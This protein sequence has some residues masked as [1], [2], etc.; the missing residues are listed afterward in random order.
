MKSKTHW[1]SWPT[2][3]REKER[4]L[5]F[6]DINQFNLTLLAI[7]EWRLLIKLDSL[8]ATLLHAK[9]FKDGDYWGA[10]SVI[11][12]FFGVGGAY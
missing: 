8:L 6:K 7:Q 1:V 12:I 2:M 4:E 3:K 5:R 10:K 11:I 9:Y